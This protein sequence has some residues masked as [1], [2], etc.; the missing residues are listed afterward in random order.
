MEYKIIRSYAGH[1]R[2]ALAAAGLGRENSERRKKP[3]GQI[4]FGREAYPP[5]AARC[6][7]LPFDLQTTQ[8]L[9]NRYNLFLMS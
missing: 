5:S 8:P 9:R 3:K 6:V 2:F 4:R 1:Y 7:G